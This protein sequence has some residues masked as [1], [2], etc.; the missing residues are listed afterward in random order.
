MGE[1]GVGKSSALAV[2][3]D[4]LLPGERP[5]DKSSLR[6]QSMLPTGAG[7]T[8]LCEVV[9]RLHQ[10]AEN[11]NEFGLLLDPIPQEEMQEIVQLW[12]EDE[13]NKRNPNAVSSS[14][15]EMP[16]NSQELLGT[17]NCGLRRV[18][19]TGGNRPTIH[20]LDG[21][22]GQY[23]SP[24]ELGQHL[25]ERLR[26]GERTQRQWWFSPGTARIEIKV[27]LDQINSGSCASALLP[28]RVTL[29]IPNFM[30]DLVNWRPT[31]NWLIL[32][33]WM[34]GLGFRVL[35][36]SNLLKIP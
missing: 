6:K 11:S 34:Q 30:E 10:G 31:F 9:S 36:C 35:I 24:D 19:E 21:V 2:T 28:R 13:W 22:V 7:R 16:S 33:G 15:G 4:L 29:V 8:T 14:D 18:P 26:L 17:S 25:H 20:P 32:V 27:L 23:G 1:V 3:A 5:T 12:A